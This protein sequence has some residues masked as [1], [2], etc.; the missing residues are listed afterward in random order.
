MGD[1]I[2]DNKD[3]NLINKVIAAAKNDDT[4]ENFM[5]WSDDQLL[6]NELDLDNAP[7][8]YN[9]R[10]IPHFANPNNKW[11]FRMRH[12][13]QYIKN[14]T[15]RDLPF[16]YDAHTPQ[17]YTKSAALDILQSVPYMEQ[18]G[19]CINTIYYGMRLVPPGALQD[20]I[21][22]T[23]EKGNVIIPNKLLTYAGYD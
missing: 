7:V 2:K 23:F 9:A 12:T 15:G 16:N 5:F 8:V 3:A 11:Y 1:P 18:P 17:P 6:T 22:V 19:F 10:Q 20:T 4:A 14:N 13:M 21:K